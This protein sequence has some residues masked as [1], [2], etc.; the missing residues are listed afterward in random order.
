MWSMLVDIFPL[1]CKE[2][3]QNKHC[4]C[5]PS[6]LNDG[7][8]KVLGYNLWFTWQPLDLMSS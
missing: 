3:L 8:M 5:E 1:Y 4:V 7:R 2:G 6:K